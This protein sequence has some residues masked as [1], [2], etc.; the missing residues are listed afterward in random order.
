MATLFVYIGLPGSG[1][2]PHAKQV[3]SF[4][5]CHCVV[6][7]S[8]GI[9]AELWGNEE[10][11]RNPAKVFELMF[12]RTVDLLKEDID[13]IYDATNLVAKR[14]KALINQ[15]SKAVP[16]T[17]FIAAFFACTIEECKARQSQRARKVPDEV[18]DRMARQFEAPWYNEGWDKIYVIS[19]GPLYNIRQEWLDLK[20]VPHDNPHHE[21]TIG[22]HSYCAYALL[23]EELADKEEQFS[24]DEIA[25]TATLFHDIGKSRTKSFRDSKGNPSEVA[26]YYNHNNVGAYMWLSGNSR[27]NLDW[28]NEFLMIGVLI[29]WHMQPYFLKN[30]TLEEWCEKKGFDEMIAYWLGL[31]HKADQSAH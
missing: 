20:N 12:K 7:S 8:D 21:Y 15:V 5:E 18:I 1:K 11:Q 9:R 17:E 26:H 14:R 22:N 4:T 10:D 29:Q 23:L 28:E 30:Q 2:S 6:V 27:L 13:V 24:D 3:A 19:S 16:D 31:I 25:L